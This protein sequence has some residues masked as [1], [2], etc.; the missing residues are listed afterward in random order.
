LRQEARFHDGSRITPQDV[1]WTFNTLITK[2]HPS[3]RV[4][5][6]DVDKC[7][8]LD[9]RR[10]RFTF[11][12]NTDR[13]LPMAVASLPVLAEHWWQDRDFAQPTLEPLLGSGP[14]RMAAVEP[15]RSITWERVKDYWAKDLPVNKGMNNF[16]TVRVD[17]YRDNSVMF[18]AFKAGQI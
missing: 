3:Y 11:K 12:S 13:D 14:Y 2:G 4:E 10:A 1:C 17:Y 18:E 16:D 8:V 9:D 7:E 5:F 15:G 6:A